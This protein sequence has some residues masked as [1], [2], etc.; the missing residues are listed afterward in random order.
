MNEDNINIPTGLRKYLHDNGAYSLQALRG[1][2]LAFQW[3]VNNLM[4]TP[5]DRV[6]YKVSLWARSLIVK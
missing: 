3:I 6:I 1:A 5:L 2:S 4:H